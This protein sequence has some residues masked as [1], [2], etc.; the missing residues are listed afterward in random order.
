MTTE[1]S[2]ALGQSTD[3]QLNI[4]SLKSGASLVSL[5]TNLIG[6]SLFRWDGERSLA[7][8][9]KGNLSR[10]A[11]STEQ[12]QT[13]RGW[14]VS[15]GFRQSRVNYYL[16]LAS[17][18]ARGV[19][20]GEDG[21]PVEC[22]PKEAAS[23]ATKGGELDGLMETEAIPALPKATPPSFDARGVA[24]PSEPDVATIVAAVIAALKG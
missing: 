10:R 1:L 15:Q 16:T 20:I 3:P 18:E 21:L 24:A 5:L 14:L 22:T 13:I 11:K 23:K 6:F 9:P 12:A 2:T 4:A 8:V 17:L 7:M 19:T